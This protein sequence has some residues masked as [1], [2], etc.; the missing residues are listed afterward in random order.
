MKDY[1]KQLDNFLKDRL[2]E[3]LLLEKEDDD[4]DIFDVD[5][6]E[7]GD[8]ENNDNEEKNLIE[9]KLIWLA[10]E[11]DILTS[12]TL[13]LMKRDS[14][15]LSLLSKINEVRGM[16]RF[17]MRNVKLYNDQEIKEISTLFEDLL[18]YFIEVFKKYHENNIE[19]NKL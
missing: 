17:F 19:S 11:Y 4:E 8:N 9:R 3:S 2:I 5:D 15:Y 12:K 1:L 10:H 7:S 13:T 6:E 14:R 16:F 18:K